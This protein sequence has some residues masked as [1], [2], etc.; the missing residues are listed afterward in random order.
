MLKQRDSSDFNS[1]L[2]VMMGKQRE[3]NPI[4][5]VLYW[6]QIYNAEPLKGT[7]IIHNYII[8]QSWWSLSNALQYHQSSRDSFQSATQVLVCSFHYLPIRPFAERFL[9]LSQLLAVKMGTGLVGQWANGSGHP[10]SKAWKEESR[11]FFEL[12]QSNL[13]RQDR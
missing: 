8:I 11:D 4:L 6:W 5:L 7:Q 2:K 9:L 12:Y 1:F 10:A 13:D 3:S